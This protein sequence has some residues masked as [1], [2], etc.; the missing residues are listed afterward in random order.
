MI[1]LYGLSLTKKGRTV[2]IEDN[3]EFFNKMDKKY[4]LLEKYLIKYTTKITQW[5]FILNSPNKLELKLPKEILK[6]KW[7]VILVDGPKGFDEPYADD[8]PGR[9]QSIYMASKLVQRDGYI[10]VDDCHRKVESTYSDKYLL[11]ENLIK[12]VKQR[13]TLRQYKMIAYN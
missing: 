12:E 3:K 11:K 2:F 6:T 13:N 9:M 4:P 10:F 1:L 7:D 5:E 8:I